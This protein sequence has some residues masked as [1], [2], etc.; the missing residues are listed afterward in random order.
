MILGEIF[1]KIT[2]SINLVTQNRIIRYVMYAVTAWLCCISIVAQA[3]L[4]GTRTIALIDKAGEET[5]IGTVLFTPAADK[6]SFTIDLETDVFTDHFLSMRPFRCIEGPEDWACHLPYPYDIRRIVSSDDLIDL[7][8]ALLFIAKKPTEFGIDAWNGR[9]YRLSI[10]DN[11]V[12]DGKL[13]EVDLNLLASPPEQAFS[14]PLQDK[15]L[16]EADPDS[17]RFP[18]LRI[19]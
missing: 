1:M 11:G 10:A 2:R 8:Y 9:Y 6:A 18:A 4:E 13:H 14:R 7:E 17:H 5:V 3:D 19:R 16:N 12:I 15:H